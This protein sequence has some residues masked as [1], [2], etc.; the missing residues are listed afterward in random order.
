MNFFLN[1][2]ISR[3]VISFIWP[4]SFKVI[5]N[6]RDNKIGAPMYYFF[7]ADF[8]F[9]GECPHYSRVFFFTFMSTCTTQQKIHLH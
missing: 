8:L 5:E 3:F 6:I 2:S 9:T 1:L 7:L 4:A